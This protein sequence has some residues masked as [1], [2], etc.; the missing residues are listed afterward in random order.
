MRIAPS[1]ARI[2]VFPARAGV[3]PLPYPS[4][5]GFVC[6]PRASGGDPR[7]MILNGKQIVYSPRERG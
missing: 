7:Y 5:P 2:V 6:I 4:T 3:I 1:T